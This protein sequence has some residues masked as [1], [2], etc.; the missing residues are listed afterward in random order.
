[1]TQI[2][3]SLANDEFQA[4]LRVNPS[5]VPAMLQIGFYELKAMHPQQ[6][7]NWSREGLR[8]EP[9]NALAEE[10][11]GRALLDLHR[12][13]D[14]LPYLEAAAQHLP[15]NAQ[16]HFHLSRVFQLL[17]R[18]ADAQKERD[19]FKRL[20]PTTPVDSVV[21]ALPETDAPVSQ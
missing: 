21:P 6:T 5:Y 9:N 17:G 10:L 13:Q 20:K 4:E 15:G 2:D 1:M 18:T 8:A 12:P 7:L 19:E 3:P 14:A 16:I 11:A